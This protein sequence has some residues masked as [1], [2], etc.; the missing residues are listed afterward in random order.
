MSDLVRSYS[1]DVSS[2]GGLETPAFSKQKRHEYPLETN[3][4]SDN[5]FTRASICVPILTLYVAYTILVLPKSLSSDTILST[6]EEF[7]NTTAQFLATDWS[8]FLLPQ[9][10]V[11]GQVLWLTTSLVPIYFIQ[12]YFGNL[13]LFLIL[14]CLFL[15]TVFILAWICT[16]SL[17]FT[18]IITFM[19]AFGTQLEYTY[20]YGDLTVLYVL[21]TYVAVNFAVAVL[22]VSGRVT[23]WDG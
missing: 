17:G 16:R 11:S 12:K 2:I 18:S 7:F 22:L 20:T 8:K 4:L 23:G 15:I 9:Q 13:N 14:S 10:Y 1:K 3:Q 6:N 21:Q 19:F 5:K